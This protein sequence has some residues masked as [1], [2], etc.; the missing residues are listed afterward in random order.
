MI[1][2]LSALPAHPDG[3]DAVEA[4]FGGL[5]MDAQLLELCSQCLDLVVTGL[6]AFGGLPLLADVFCVSPV[7]GGGAARVGAGWADVGWSVGGVWAGWG[8][9]AVG[10]GAARPWFLCL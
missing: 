10:R 9:R 2:H 7:T 5:K 4:Q 6:A 8:D 1:G 3:A